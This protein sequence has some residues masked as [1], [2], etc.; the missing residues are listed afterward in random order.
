M[1]V[2]QI[3]L[4]STLGAY[5]HH[6]NGSDTSGGT[7]TTLLD[8]V[9]FNFPWLLVAV[10]LAAFIIHSIVTAEP[11]TESAEPQL[12]GPGG[13]PLPRSMRKIRAE[14]ERRKRLQD[15]SPNRKL[16]FLWLSA[17]ILATFLGNAIN[18]VVHALT[19][20]DSSWWCGE[21]TAVSNIQ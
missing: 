6:H 10:Y 17:G 12:T 1:A 14:W 9:H 5:N 16:V 20:R 19:E 4:S 21:A 13:K 18:I 2:E 11:S 15:F 7:R 3:E 8:N